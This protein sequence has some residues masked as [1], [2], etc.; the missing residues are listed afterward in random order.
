MAKIKGPAIF[1]AQFLD[2]KAPFNTLEGITGWAKSLGFVGV[3]IPA[4]DGRVLDPPSGAT[5]GRA[6]GLRHALRRVRGA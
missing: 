3:Q 2:D 6:P 4:W 1:L 5:G